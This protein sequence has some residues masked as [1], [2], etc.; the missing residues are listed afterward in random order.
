GR[1]DIRYAASSATDP[2]LASLSTGGN[3]YNLTKVG[4]NFVGIVSATV[5]PNL[6]DINVLGGT[7]GVEG[8]TIGLGNPANTLTVAAGAALQLYNL[9][10]Q[11]NKIVVLD[12]NGTNSTMINASGANTILGPI[13][14]NG[15]SVFSGNGTSLTLSGAI[16]GAGG[17]SKT[18]SGV[19]V[20]AGNNTYSGSTIVNTGMLAIVG[21][22][23]GGGLLTN[24]SGST[25]VGTGTHSG[26]VFIAGT[27]NPGNINVAGAFSCGPLTLSSGGTLTL[28]LGATTTPD[29]SVNDLMNVAGDL[30]L[31]NNSVAINLL[32][33]TL[34]PG[35]Y[36]LINY[37]GN[38]V[39]S[40]NPAVAL[41]VGGSSRYTLTLDTSTPQQVNLIVSGSP[42]TVKWNSTA[43]S[44]WDVASTA[45]WLNVGTGD[46]TVF[47][48]ADSVLLDDT[49]GVQPNLTLGAIVVPSAVTVNSA[50]N[51]F[52]ITGAG[53]ISGATSIIKQG[54]STLLLGTTNDF[55]GPVLVQGGI[56][57]VTNNSALGATNSGTIISSGATLDVCG[58]AANNTLNL[59]LEPVIVSGA[60]VSGIGAIIN[61]STTISQNAALRVVTLADDTTFGGTGISTVSSQPGRWDIR[62]PSTGDPSQSRLSTGGHAYKLTKV[63]PNQISLVG[64]SVDP[65]L[66]DI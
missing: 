1:W 7:L 19:L 66:G 43:D 64:T 9:T 30:V 65:A 39:G 54:A 37:S 25:I 44:T 51:N 52:S 56:L 26:P 27:L 53:K 59:G 57:Q 8:N 13:T 2:A 55:L 45:N 35:S 24:A 18:S 20:L 46:T 15:T 29:G 3:A 10:N 12:G 41:A 16:G 47:A 5:D 42:A 48:Q 50:L 23:A 58:A 32:Q 60:G 61:S 4:S 6:A 63:G 62:S 14:L 11:V 22:N 36:R 49:P 34:A 21:M 17:L 28:D 40:F 38:L 33:G 31:N